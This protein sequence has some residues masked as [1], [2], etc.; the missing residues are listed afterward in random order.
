LHR[1]PGPAAARCPGGRDESRRAGRVSGTPA[2][3]EASHRT[4]RRISCAKGVEQMEE[5]SPKLPEAESIATPP[6][7]MMKKIMRLSPE[8]QKMMRLLFGLEDGRRRT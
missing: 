8:Q 1:P 2:A 6:D 5:H 7:W 4:R 3:K